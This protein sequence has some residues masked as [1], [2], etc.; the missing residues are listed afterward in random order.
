[1]YIYIYIRTAYIF[2]Y[3]IHPNESAVL[4]PADLFCVVLF[5]FGLVLFHD[6]AFMAWRPAWPI[7]HSFWSIADTLLLT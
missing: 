4:R 5:W 3:P 7:M 2:I 1:M 6:A